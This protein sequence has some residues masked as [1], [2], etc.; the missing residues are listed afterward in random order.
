MSR[1]LTADETG[2]HKLVDVGGSDGS[3][4]VAKWGNQSREAAVVAL[5]WLPPSATSA[6][7][8]ARAA[9]SGGAADDDAPTSSARAVSLTKA[10]ALEVWDTSTRAQLHRIANAGADAVLLATRTT[11]FVTVTSAG[12]VRTFSYN[13]TD[14]D[15]DAGATKVSPTPRTCYVNA[16]AQSHSG[17]FPVGSVTMYDGMPITAFMPPTL[18]FHDA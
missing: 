15:A 9:A 4:V 18:L 17:R 1:V 14:A 6:L 5:A 7:H 16:A 11:G 2:V 3:N 13:A 8:A 10:G 12:V